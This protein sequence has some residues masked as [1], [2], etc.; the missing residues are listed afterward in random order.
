M[1]DEVANTRKKIVVFEDDLAFRS[2]YVSGLESRGFEV[3]VY[4]S[5]KGVSIDELK[6]IKPNLISYDIFMPGM[7]GI[8]AAKA[9]AKDPDLAS[10][11]FIF[12]SSQEGDIRKEAEALG[13]EAF[14]SKF[15]TPISEIVNY[16][17]QLLH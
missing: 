15:Q 8:E 2:S 4:T 17:D 16:I 12:V 10:V 13:S 9:F 5:P 3:V 1:S 14:F 11:P 7:S 6:K